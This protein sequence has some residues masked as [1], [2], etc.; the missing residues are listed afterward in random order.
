MSELDRAAVET[1]EQ[2]LERCIRQVELACRHAPNDDISD[3]LDDMH[4]ALEDMRSDSVWQAR[5]RLEELE[6][7]EERRHE[8]M[9]RSAYLGSVV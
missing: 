4:K 1:A 5:N 7:A 2:A 3:H 6:A 9:E 8:A